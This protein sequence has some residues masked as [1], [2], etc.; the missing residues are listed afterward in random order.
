MTG[1]PIAIRRID[2]SEFEPE[3]EA[4]LTDYHA[5][6]AEAFRTRLT[7]RI[8]GDRS[9]SSDTPFSPESYLQGELATDLEYLADPGLPRPIVVALRR[10]EV[11]GCVYLYHLAEAL[12]EVKR[13][14]VRPTFRGH[15]IGRDLV[16]RLIEV[17]AS[18][19]YERLRLDTAAFMAGA[20]RLYTDLGF[21]PIEPHEPISAIP[22]RLLDEI[23]FMELELDAGDPE[24]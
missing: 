24:R 9:G 22:D 18:E 21:E 4:I 15:G 14:Y 10:N 1:T 13:L 11:V 19:G 7:R 8:D 20:H 2:I 16:E 23:A 3:I 6:V 5:W 17:A 12:A